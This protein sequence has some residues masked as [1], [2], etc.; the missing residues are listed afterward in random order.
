MAMNP[1]IL[2]RTPDQRTGKIY[3]SIYFRTLTLPYLN[4][5]H[6]MFYKNKIKIIP[7]NLDK[8]LTPIGLAY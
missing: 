2:T 8:L 3:K 1:I 6:D 7:E 5:Y 4:E